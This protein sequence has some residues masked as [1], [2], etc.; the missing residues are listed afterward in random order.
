MVPQ[1]NYIYMRSC[2]VSV[3]TPY[4]A[5]PLGQYLFGYCPTG[6]S[7]TRAACAKMA[8]GPTLGPW[9]VGCWTAEASPAYA[10]GPEKNGPRPDTLR[11]LQIQQLCNAW[12]LA[13]WLLDGRGLPRVR[14]GSRGKWPSAR[15]VAYADNIANVA[16]G[17]TR[18]PWPDTLDAGC[19]NAGCVNEGC[20]T[21]LE[22]KSS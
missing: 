3:G 13:R 5:L 15:R 6:G 8:L 7:H 20:V 12:P 17:P 1:R 10:G 16:L 21:K 9:L 19:V 4:F 18:G 2:C 14:R 22:S 11:K